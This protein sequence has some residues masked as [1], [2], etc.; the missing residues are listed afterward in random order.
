[1]RSITELMR[2]PGFSE[3][4]R[5]FVKREVASILQM[6]GENVNGAVTILRQL[7]SN[8]HGGGHSSGRSTRSFIVG[9]ILSWIN[10]EPPEK[11]TGT[12]LSEARTLLAVLVAMH[13]DYEYINAKGWYDFRL[14]S[15]SDIPLSDRI[16]VS[17]AAFALR[18]YEIPTMEE[19]DVPKILAFVRET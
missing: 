5:E 4:Q 8:Y 18:V 7:S 15:I 12:R 2:D 6:C 1:M 10:P 17:A 13:Y 19:W 3:E 11:V 9:K 14:E 16:L